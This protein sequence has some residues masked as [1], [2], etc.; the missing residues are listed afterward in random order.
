[1]RISISR[2]FMGLRS[3]HIAARMPAHCVPAVTAEPPTLADG[4][5]IVSRVTYPRTLL[6]YAK[7]LTRHTRFTHKNLLLAVTVALVAAFAVFQT[8][9]FRLDEPDFPIR[10]FLFISV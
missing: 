2:I 9:V 6:T 1:M 5:N 8:D 10:V 7:W 3:T 4:P